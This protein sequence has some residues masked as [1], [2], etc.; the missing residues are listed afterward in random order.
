MHSNR[1][2]KRQPRLAQPYCTLDKVMYG[3]EDA[4]DMNP[5][6]IVKKMVEEKKH[7][8]ILD[9]KRQLRWQ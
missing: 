7:F 1:Y 5:D 4:T 6:E 3:L 9:G 2:A 8:A